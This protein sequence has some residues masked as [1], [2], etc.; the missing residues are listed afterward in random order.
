LRNGILRTKRNNQSTHFAAA[1]HIHINPLSTL[2][3]TLSVP[4]LLS[5]DDRGHVGHSTR[6]RLVGTEETADATGL[7]VTIQYN[8]IYYARRPIPAERALVTNAYI[9]HLIFDFVSSSPS[10]TTHCSN[11]VPH[12]LEPILHFTFLNPIEIRFLKPI[13]RLVLDSAFPFSAAVCILPML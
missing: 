7:I 3:A 1:Y 2:S 11:C 12:F 4:H 5:R 8:T 6:L 10:C 9:Q 13:L